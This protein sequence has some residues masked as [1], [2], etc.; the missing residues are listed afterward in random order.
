L[1]A[2]RVFRTVRRRG[3][4]GAK[5]V[6]ARRRALFSEP[7]GSGRAAARLPL[8]AERGGRQ[9]A[10]CRPPGKTKAA[11]GGAGGCAKIRSGRVEVLAAGEV[12]RWVG[13]RR[14]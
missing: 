3:A 8:R 11:E 13:L 6:A 9:E 10:D 4:G 14:L 2:R 12:L 5:T 1:R 7:A